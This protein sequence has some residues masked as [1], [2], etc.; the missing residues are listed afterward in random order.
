MKDNRA[1]L[2]VEKC[3]VSIGKSLM[4]AFEQILSKALFCQIV[5]VHQSHFLNLACNRHI[6]YQQD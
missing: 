6:G 2:E 5:Y 4:Q 1:A 3:F